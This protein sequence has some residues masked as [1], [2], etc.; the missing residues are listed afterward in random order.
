MLVKDESYM[1]L[2]ANSFGVKRAHY[3]TA[4]R[5]RDPRNI[6]KFFVKN[7]QLRRLENAQNVDS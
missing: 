3:L 6:H 1:K 5:P 7:P 4:A 2:V